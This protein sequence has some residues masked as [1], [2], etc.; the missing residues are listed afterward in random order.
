M[1]GLSSAGLLEE[2]D[3]IGK[4]FEAM[5][6]QNAKLLAQLKDKDDENFR[7]MSSRV[8]DSSKQTVLEDAAR[9]RDMKLKALE[10]RVEA[11]AVC[12][13]KTEEAEKL[14]QE[15]LTKLMA[16]LSAS[17]QLAESCR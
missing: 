6:E 5:Q 11:Q 17:H 3:E 2:L 10:E 4:S 13:Q 9:A 16:E 1:H 12:L 7:L 8:K 14:A 15:Q